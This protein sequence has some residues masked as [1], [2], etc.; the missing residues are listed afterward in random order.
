MAAYFLFLAHTI[1]R[2]DTRD[3]KGGGTE[4]FI[5]EFDDWH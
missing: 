1:L 3:E 2:T 5:R 4:D